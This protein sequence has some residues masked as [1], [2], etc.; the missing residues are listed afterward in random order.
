[1]NAKLL[2]KTI[3]LMV[4]L[5]LF[6][7]I[8]FYNRNSVSFVLPPILPKAISQPAG[9]MYFAFFAV[10]V[11][12]GTILT[13]GGGGGKSSGGGGSSKPSKPSKS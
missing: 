1:M 9:F 5:L 4:F 7:M 8:G 6:V 12:V 13:A 10:G 2:F 11:I 3:F